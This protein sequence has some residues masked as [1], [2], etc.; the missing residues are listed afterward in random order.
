MIESFYSPRLELFVYVEMEDSGSRKIKRVG[1][2]KSL[3]G[4]ESRSKIIA[5]LKKHLSGKAVDF[6]RYS[7]SLS[8]LTSFER[9][10]LKETRKIPY[11][12][13]LSYLELADRAGTKAVRGVGNALAKNP[14]PIIIPCHRVLRKNRE[15]GGYSAGVE[16]KKKLLEIEGISTFKR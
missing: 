16:I 5:D 14:V 6:S 15:L 10:V 2:S 8:N 4:K 9:S 11:G 13:T 1:F 7:L 3:R 12:K